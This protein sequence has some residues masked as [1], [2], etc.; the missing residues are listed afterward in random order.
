VA[1][2]E[3]NCMMEEEMMHFAGFDDD[4]LVAGKGNDELYGE[5]GND[6]LTV[7]MVLM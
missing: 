5:A 3:M 2:E 6:C 7:E 1:K 4:L